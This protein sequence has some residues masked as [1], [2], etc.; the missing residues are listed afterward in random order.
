MEQKSGTS[1]TM[2]VLLLTYLC[3]SMLSPLYGQKADTVINTG[4]YKSYFSYSIKAPLYVTYTLYRGGGDCDRDKEGFK[5]LQGGILQSASLNDYDEPIYDQG[6]LANAE[7]FAADCKKEEITFRFY[8]CFPQTAKLNRGIWRSWE[9]TIRKQSHAKRLFVI[10]GGI[11]GKKFIG[12]KV[13]VPEYCYKI[14]LDSRTKKILYCVIFKNDNSNSYKHISL[15]SLKKRLR[16]P[17]M[18]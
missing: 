15:A 13:A 9:S 2:R 6:H 10:A 17:L 11:Y 1:G 4:L 18:P 14:V 16:Y 5:F 12:A 8:N 7:D 3:T